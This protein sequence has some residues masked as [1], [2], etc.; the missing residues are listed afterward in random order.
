MKEAIQIRSLTA[1]IAED[2]DLIRALLSSYCTKSG[3]HIVAQTRSGQDVVQLT[4]QHLPD[5]VILD[6]GLEDK[7]GIDAAKEIQQNDLGARSPYIIIVTG[8]TDPINVMTAVNELG[9]FYI[10]KPLLIDRWNLVIGKIVEDFELNAALHNAHS[11]PHL[12]NIHTSRKSYPIA[13][14]TI[15]MIEKEYG[16]KSIIIHLTSGKTIVS[17]STLY[18][19]REQSSDFL[20]ESIRGYLVN[21]CHVAGYAR[22]ENFLDVIHRRYTIF[23]KNSSITAPLGKTQEKSF[24]ERFN[25]FKKGI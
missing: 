22:E 19:I 15:L 21:I 9:T 6:I 18:Q 14:E 20:F 13:E 3:I 11:T 5:I 4:K 17:N 12:I 10:V 2:D 16:R 25:H 23:F 24:S 1:V 7:S 8:S